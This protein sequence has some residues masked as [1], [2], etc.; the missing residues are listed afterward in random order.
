MSMR[1]EEIA[2]FGDL[3]GEAAAGAAK[4]IHEL[5]VGIAGRVWRHVGPA[6]LPVR[7]AH[8]RI[9]RGA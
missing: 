2:G 8:D 6:A 4:Q 3:A 1:P 9:A 5:H 7:V